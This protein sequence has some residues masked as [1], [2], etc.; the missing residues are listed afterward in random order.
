M[1][2]RDGKGLPQMQAEAAIKLLH[3]RTAGTMVAL[4]GYRNREPMQQNIEG[5]LL[6]RAFNADVVPEKSF[7]EGIV[8]FRGSGDKKNRPVELFLPFLLPDAIPLQW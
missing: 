4:L 8:Y 6:E 2:T 1:K 7:V 3:G 5:R